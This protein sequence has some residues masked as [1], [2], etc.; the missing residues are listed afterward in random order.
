MNEQ[1]CT[2]YNAA[3]KPKAPVVTETN[4]TFA[5]PTATDAGVTVDAATPI[6]VSPKGPVKT[7]PSKD[8]A[9]K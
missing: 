8:A 2:F 7:E 9:K 3:R 1:D 6:E 4:M 5:A